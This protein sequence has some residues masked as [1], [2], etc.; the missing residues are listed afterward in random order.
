MLCI[1]CSSAA[2]EVSHFHAYY[3]SIV[4]YDLEGVEQESADESLNRMLFEKACDMTL[5]RHHQRIIGVSANSDYDTMQSA[6]AA[7]VDAFIPKPFKIDVFNKTY[8][9]LVSG[10]RSE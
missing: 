7:G 5:P 8:T 3:P 1:M 10:V 4:T 6:F 2:D 9:E